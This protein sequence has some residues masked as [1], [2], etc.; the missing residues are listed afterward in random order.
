MLIDFFE[1]RNK[2]ITEFEESVFES[3]IKKIVVINQKEL[4]FNLIGGLK[5]TEYC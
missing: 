4:E 5:F 3:I 1:R 2:P